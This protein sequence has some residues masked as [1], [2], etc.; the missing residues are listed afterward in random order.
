MESQTVGHDWATERNWTEHE[1]VMGTHMSP[2]SWT[3]HPIP[4]LWVVAEPQ[5]ELP[6]SY[7][8]SP[9][10]IY[11][12]YSNVYV[13]MLLSQF[14]PPLL[15]LPYPQ[16]VL[17]VFVSFAELPMKYT[18]LNVL[19]FTDVVAC[20]YG[21]FFL[22]PS[23]ISLYGYATICL[24]LLLMEISCIRQIFIGFVFNQYKT[25]SDFSFLLRVLLFKNYSWFTILY[26]SCV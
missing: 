7:N 20:I 1:S 14:V 23:G 19:R 15:P 12:T 16:S 6:A 2:P 22:L 10:V 4:S 5:D 21:L 11:F 13:S 3:S 8:K 18:Q 26:V 17:F 25:F 9:L 24:S